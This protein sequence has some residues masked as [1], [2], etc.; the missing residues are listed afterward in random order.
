MTQH[1]QT[2]FKRDSCREI[3]CMLAF[4]FSAGI[5]C[6]SYFS[7]RTGSVSIPLMRG[8][9]DGSVSIVSLLLT[10]FLP[11][12]LSFAS[13]VLDS[14]LLF[15]ICFCRGFLFSYIQTGLILSFRSSGW[16][17]R[18]LVLFSDGISQAV[19]YLFWRQSIVKSHV[20]RE[21]LVP[22]VC[23]L[24]LIGLFDFYIILPYYK[25]F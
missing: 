15:P 6:G 18:W 23:L 12:L 13:C 21:L 4:F 24:V 3:T 17:L 5:L 8:I 19:L 14:V 9:P 11:F 2:L 10:L 25:A 1:F 20:R 7:F 22:F 16:L